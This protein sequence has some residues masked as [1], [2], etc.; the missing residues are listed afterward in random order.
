[1]IYAK[2]SDTNEIH[3]KSVEDLKINNKYFR[4]IFKI[5][6]GIKKTKE[7]IVDRHSEEKP[8]NEIICNFFSTDCF[9]LILFLL[10]QA[11]SFH[12][13]LHKL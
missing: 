13:V 1:M 10:M 5:E 2:I 7:K 9:F 8:I 11:Y 4:L 3:T 6:Y 12:H